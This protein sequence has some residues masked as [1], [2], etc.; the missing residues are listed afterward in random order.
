MGDLSKSVGFCCAVAKILAT[1][2]RAKKRGLMLQ[3]SIKKTG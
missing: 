3:I 1:S 2:A